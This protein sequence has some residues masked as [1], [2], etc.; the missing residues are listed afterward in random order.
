LS[1][2]IEQNPIFQ[3]LGRYPTSVL[4]FHDPIL[5]LAGL[6]SSWEHGQQRSKILVGSKEMAF[7]NFVCAED[8]VD[9]S[10]LPKEPSPGFGTGSPP[11]IPY[12]AMELIHS[13]DLEFVA[14]PSAF[15]EVLLSKK[16]L[17]L[18]RPTPSKT[19]ALVACSPK[20]TPSSIL[21]SNM[22]SPPTD[23]SVV[24]PLS[25]QGYDPLHHVLKASKEAMGKV[26]VNFL[27]DYLS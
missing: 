10:F 26:N 18:Q 5:F 27:D 20:A 8:E 15:I 3:R 6:Q 7:R 4:V 25:S 21:G 2:N 22:M 1:S 11:F 12:A 16:P 17:S 23:A 24:K 13:D 19:Q 9:L 14:D